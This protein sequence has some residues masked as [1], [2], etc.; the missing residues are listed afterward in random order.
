MS[1]VLLAYVVADGLFLLMGIFMIAFSVIVQNIQFEIPTEGHQAARNLLYQRFPITAGIVNAVFIFVTFLFTIPGVITPAR[2]WLKMG[3]WMTTVCGL[4]SLILG[5][6]LWILTLKTKEDFALLYFQQTPEIQQLMQ[7]AFQCCGY[8]NST[9]PAF[10]TDDICS[11]PAAA[12]LMRPCATPIASFANILV[13]NIFTAVFGMVGID[14]VLIMATACLLKE[15]KERE[16][17]RHIDLKSGVVG[18]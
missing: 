16:R 7:S 15:R 3:G 8:F 17:F 13:D 5:L 1:K 11:S 14:V 12:A 9:S 2:G 4:F 10:I 18:F 6:Y